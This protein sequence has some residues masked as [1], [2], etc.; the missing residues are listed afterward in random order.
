MA[1]RKNRGKSVRELSVALCDIFKVPTELRAEPRTGM[2]LIVM[3]NSHK[4]TRRKQ[5]LPEVRSFMGDMVDVIMHSYSRIF[6]DNNA[7]LRSQF[8]T[9]PLIRFLWPNFLT[10]HSQQIMTHLRK[11]LN[12]QADGNKRRLFLLEISMLEQETYF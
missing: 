3:V 11:V 10:K 8:F 6:V 12:E 1:A 7:Q 2:A 4:I 5:L 9:D